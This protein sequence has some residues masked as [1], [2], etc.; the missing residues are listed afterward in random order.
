MEGANRAPGSLQVLVRQSITEFRERHAFDPRVRE[1]CGV[2]TH[3]G[4]DLKPR[5]RRA[6]SLRGIGLQG[7][8]FKAASHGEPGTAAVITQ[9]E[10][11]PRPAQ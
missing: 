3:S 4:N 2:R 9:P 11:A 6:S 7:L 5:N 10:L 1:S 8:V